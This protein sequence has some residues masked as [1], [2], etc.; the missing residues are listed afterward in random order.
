MTTDNTTPY[1]MH[2][3]WVP[4]FE[5]LKGSP[6]ED[7]DVSEAVYTAD[8]DD[9]T[10]LPAAQAL[11][12]AYDKAKDWEGPIDCED[13]VNAVL[14]A[15][16]EFH[17]GYMLTPLQVGEMADHFAIFYKDMADPLQD[18]LDE[19]YSRMDLSWLSNYG[20]GELEKKIKRPSEIWIA[21]DGLP[22]VWVFNKPGRKPPTQ[23]ERE[24]D[25][26]R[27][28]AYRRANGLIP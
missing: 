6:W 22:G 8:P 17:G 18:R 27:E 25:Y 13:A 15:A 5:R 21:G 23:T 24:K 1:D 28:M 2:A 4:L 3:V 7:E 11:K 20:W 26:Q 19:E 14:A 10:K 12:Y 16:S 9:H